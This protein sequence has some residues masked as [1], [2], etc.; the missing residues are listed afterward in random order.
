MRIAI[1]ARFYGSEHTGLGRYTTNVLA[2]LPRYLKGQTL[3]VLLRSKYYNTLKLPKNCQK[4]LAD[5]SHYSLAEQLY[6]PL[7]LSKLGSDLLYTFHFNA[8]ILSRVP[9]VL[10]VHDLIKS[11]FSGPETTTRSPWL[12][13]LKRAGY[14]YVLRRGVTHAQAIIVPTNTV[15][16]QLLTN[17]PS[18]PPER[19]HPIPEAPDPIFCIPSTAKVTLPPNYLLFVGNAYPHKNLSVLLDA[20]TQLPTEHLVIVAHESPFLIRLLSG[21]DLSRIHLLSSLTDPELVFVYQQARA[22]V[23]P[24][25]MEGYG[26]PGLEALMVGTPVISSNI[27]V[28]REVYGDKVTYFD[29]QSV[30][31]LVRVITH[32]GAT[33]PTSFKYSRTWDQVACSIAEVIHESCARL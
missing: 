4:V 31:D 5:F 9:S 26:L 16:N 13:S 11:Y 30:S 15:K 22:L 17:F 7:L 20:L 6:L 18:L 2:H 14:Q 32:L 3:Q 1:D 10:T 33:S 8:P 24:S 12:Y 27:P 28:Y 29:P 23:A 25:L 21:R 19:V